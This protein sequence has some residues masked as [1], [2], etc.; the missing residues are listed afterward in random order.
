MGEELLLRS[1]QER[2]G[3]RHACLRVRLAFV[4]TAPMRRAF[5]SSLVA[6][7][8]CFVITTEPAARPQDR[9]EVPI[10]LDPLAAA[11]AA[12]C[13]AVAASCAAFAASCAAVAARGGAIRNVVGTAGSAAVIGCELRRRRGEL[14]GS[15]GEEFR[16][17]R[18]GVGREPS[19]AAAAAVAARGSAAAAIAA[20]SADA[21]R[22]ISALACRGPSAVVF[23]GRLPPPLRK[24]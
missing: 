1:L 3:V 9:T 7:A 17:V 20:T 19:R 18:L 10:A 24:S 22:K 12:S 4:A 16:V 8:M 15:V 6:S 2:I 11:V 13:A 14:R 5:C 21:R 23:G